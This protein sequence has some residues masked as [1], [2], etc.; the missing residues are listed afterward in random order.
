MPLSVSAIAAV[1]AALVADITEA[2]NTRT[3]HTSPPEVETPTGGD[4]LPVAFVVV[5]AAP[6][7]S[8]L[9]SL[10]VSVPVYSVRI[11]GRFE[12][13]EG[14][15]LMPLKDGKADAL[16]AVLTA[17]PGVYS[18]ANWFPDEVSYDPFPDGVSDAGRKFYELELQMVFHVT[19]A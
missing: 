11:R 8:R 3:V 17:T 9:N 14:V 12:K 18:S 19:G 1:R 5:D 15:E 6:F 13:P 16:L 4:G 2:W 7:D 10:C